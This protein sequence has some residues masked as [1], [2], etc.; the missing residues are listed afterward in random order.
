MNKN[1]T[2]EQE[3]TG[4]DYAHHSLLGTVRQGG[5]G[6]KEN[7]ETRA[8]KRESWDGEA[9]GDRDSPKEE[10]AEQEGEKEREKRGAETQK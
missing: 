5:E 8:R 10:A 7:G 6:S 4:K 1:Q 9:G 3:E 2:E